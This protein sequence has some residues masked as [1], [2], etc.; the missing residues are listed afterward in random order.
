M[1]F[2]HIPSFEDNFTMNIWLKIWN[3]KISKTFFDFVNTL[4]K[5]L[6]T[7]ISY[8]YIKS[9]IDP[10][11]LENM[12]PY[13]KWLDENMQFH[14]HVKST[15]EIY[16]E[17]FAQFFM[18]MHFLVFLA[19]FETEVESEINETLEQFKKFSSLN[20]I[21]AIIVIAVT[22]FKSTRDSL[23]KMPFV[24]VLESLNRMDEKNFN[25]Y[26]RMMLVKRLEEKLIEVNFNDKSL[27]LMDHETFKNL[28]KKKPLNLS[29]GKMMKLLGDV[30]FMLNSLIDAQNYY[31]KALEIFQYEQKHSSKN[32]EIISLWICGIYESMAACVYY[33]IKILL[34]SDSKNANDIKG[35][36][37]EMDKL[38]EKIISQFDKDKKHQLYHQ[39]L[40]KMIEIYSLTKNKQRFIEIFFKLRVMYLNYQY[41]DQSVF[42]HIGELAFKTG[43]NRIAV[44]AL[45]E[46]SKQTKQAEKLESV[47]RLSLNFCAKILNL[48]LENYFNNFEMVERLPSKIVEVILI[49]LIDINNQSQNNLKRLHYYLLL[50]K[51]YENNDWVFNEITKKLHWEYPIYESEYDILPFIQRIVPI[52]KQKIFQPVSGEESVPNEKPLK[53]QESVFIYDP[54]KKTKFVELN[55]VSQ[56]QAEVVLY[57][58][59]PLNKFV[60]IDAISLETE[61]VDVANYSNQINLR[62]KI[63]NYEYK[64]KI[65]PVQSGFLKIKGVKIRIGNLIYINTVDQRG[66]SNI[67]KYI[68]RDNPNFYERHFQNCEID[69]YKIPVAES[70]PNLS[71]SVRNYVPETIFYNENISIE[72]KITN[73]SKIC[74][75]Q[76]KIHF[77]IDYENAYTVLWENIPTGFELEGNSSFF[78]VF[79][80][81]QGKFCDKESKF[82]IEKIGT[83]KFVLFLPNKQ[84]H[85][86]VY[87]VTLKIE[88][89]FDNNKAFSGFKD[90]SKFFKNYKLFEV[91]TNV[92][93]YYG[94]NSMSSD[95]VYKYIDIS[96]QV[97]LFYEIELKNH[98]FSFQ[99]I[100]I[101]LLKKETGE[102]I[103]KINFSE[104]NI[105]K[106]VNSKQ[107]LSNV[108]NLNKIYELVWSIKE[109]NRNGIIQYDFPI[110]INVGLKAK[111]QS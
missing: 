32:P 73:Q 65:R 106:V 92:V 36:I 38:G 31:K 90:I 89:K 15:H 20:S 13:H 82:H 107:E 41:F 76:F 103:D 71:L 39:L 95:G 85:E 28:L 62:P 53:E 48:N 67:Y 42:L 105:V 77:K 59:N 1:D 49:N 101:S 93:D 60:T 63:L 16:Q 102:T 35:E 66:L 87:K 96:D 52:G 99:N 50:L 26:F 83:D 8:K 78:I 108:D 12:F 22:S 45:F 111:L 29:N 58:T 25:D 55:W 97:Q 6:K 64:F 104:K 30:S 46:Y 5:F 23:S 3:I 98:S 7:Q 24:F 19:N 57:F 4:N 109:N 10:E 51:K 110:V 54:R 27:A 18:N 86:R 47:R 72:Y 70:V 69:I 14:L 56:E 94:L 9:K 75:K 84:I 80:L 43:L 40:L 74:A 81:N 79:T 17:N 68:K 91:K 88:S 34:S 44:C 33:K 11:V 21:S 61:E 2:Y 37:S 100:E